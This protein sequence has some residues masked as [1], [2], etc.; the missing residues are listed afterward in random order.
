MTQVIAETKLADHEIDHHS[1][2]FVGKV[3]CSANTGVVG[4]IFRQGC[5]NAAFTKVD[6]YQPRAFFAV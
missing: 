6:L 4:F 3:L 2:I 5:C 1:A